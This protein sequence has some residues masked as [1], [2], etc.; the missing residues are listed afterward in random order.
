MP[1]ITF[2]YAPGACSL[3]T[4]ILLLEI[5]VEFEGISNEV[6]PEKAIFVDKFQTINSKMRVPVLV[7]DS[8][9]ITETPAI[10]ESTSN[11]DASP[12]LDENPNGAIYSL[13]SRTTATAIAHLAPDA[14]LLGKSPMEIVRT[15]EWMNWLYG[16]FHVNV[17]SNARNLGSETCLGVSRSIKHS[18]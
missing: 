16:Y 8:D 4:H 14:N 10:S 17:T 6:T 13:Y 5:G 3:A 7:V 15:Y 9:I 1:Q 12:D 2:Y 11:Y 18:I